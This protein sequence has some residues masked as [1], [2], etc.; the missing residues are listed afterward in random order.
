MTRRPVRARSRL[1]AQ[2]H[3]RNFGTARTAVSESVGSLHLIG[4]LKDSKGCH[5]ISTSHDS[6][7]VHAGFS[8]LFD[9]SMGSVSV[10]RGLIMVGALDN[11]TRTIYTTLSSTS[12]PSIIK[13]VTNSSAVFVTYQATSL[14]I[15]LA[16]RLG[17]LV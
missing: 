12:C 15:S 7:S 11:V 6:A 4:A 5:C 16:R 3:R 1:L 13:A 10:T 14:T 9:A 17:G 8:G 2:L